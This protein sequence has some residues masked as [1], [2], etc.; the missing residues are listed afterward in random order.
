M[1]I[2]D[3]VSLHTKVTLTARLGGRSRI[4][5]IAASHLR[6]TRARTVP[7]ETRRGYQRGIYQRAF[8]VQEPPGRQSGIG[9]VKSIRVKIV[10]PEQMPKSQQE[11]QHPVGQKMHAVWP[12][13]QAIQWA[14]KGTSFISPSYVRATEAQNDCS[15]SPGTLN[16]ST[17]LFPCFVHRDPRQSIAP[18]QRTI[19]IRKCPCGFCGSTH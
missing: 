11:A 8:S 4:Q 3:K 16:R 9:S 12:G 5:H 17:V 19:T 1:C 7:G 6:I 2:Q 10:L 14:S 15:A 18:E 13:E